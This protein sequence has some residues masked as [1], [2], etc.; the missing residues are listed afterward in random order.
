MLVERCIMVPETRWVCVREV[1]KSIARSVKQLISDKIDRL[2]VRSLFGE[3]KTEIKTPGGGVIIFQGMQQHTS[4]TIKSLEGF[5]GAWVEEA[6]TLSQTSLNMLRPTLR[7]TER[8]NSRPEPEL[9]FTWNPRSE[10][11][12]VDRFFRQPGEAPPRSIIREVNW[13]DNPWFPADLR[14]E[15][16]YDRRRDPDKYSHIWLGKYLS[17]TEARV[18]KNW[19]IGGFDLPLDKVRNHT[20]VPLFGADWGG[21]HDPTVLVRCWIVER[22]NANGER[23][24]PILYID[25]EAYNVGCPINQKP[26]LFRSIEDRLV[27]EVKRWPITADSAWPDTIS[28][29]KGAGFNMVGA[30]KGAGSVEEGVEFLKTFDIIV[31]E[32]CKHTIDELTLYS[33]EIDKNDDKIILPVL[34]DKHNHVIDAL[35][36]AVES[37][38]AATTGMINFYRE[39]TQAF[40]A[41][42]APDH[43]WSMSSPDLPASENVRMFAP[44]GH[45]TVYGLSGRMYQVEADGSMVVA[46]EDVG[47]LR[48]QG[49]RGGEVVE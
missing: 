1:Q 32:R 33:Y 42:G 16:D 26:A 19:T 35:R 30:R 15:M 34:R 38:R 24:V 41:P 5:D 4:E 45:T 21:T 31:N 18:F 37:T 10:K 28:Y 9:W 43:G 3:F 11:D 40:A 25:Q 6:Q 14:E 17:R 47:P 36:Y 8:H 46:P 23:I 22:T 39:E 2:G 48:G 49:F 7:R 13:R 44:T 27:P 29:M 12:A 20:V